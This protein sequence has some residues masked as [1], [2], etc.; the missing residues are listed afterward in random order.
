[1]AVKPNR[2]AGKVRVNTT[3][4]VS[5]GAGMTEAGR[6]AYNAKNGKSFTSTTSKLAQDMTVFAQEAN[7]GMANRGKATRQGG[8]VPNERTIRKHSLKARKRIKAWL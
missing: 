6:K 2:A 5:E 1:M 7:I 8:I 3:L 4:P